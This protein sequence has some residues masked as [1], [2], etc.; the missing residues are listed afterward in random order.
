MGCGVGGGCGIGQWVGN[1]DVDVVGRGVVVADDV[2]AGLFVFWCAWV[3]VEFG[4]V[5]FE[6]CVVAVF[7][8]PFLEGAYERVVLVYSVS[9]RLTRGGVLAVLVKWV[10][11]L[12]SGGGVLADGVP[13]RVL[14]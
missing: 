5:D 8:E 11:A 1:T 2:H 14:C 13:S 6:L 7:F 3:F 10:W 9:S 4:D 12:C